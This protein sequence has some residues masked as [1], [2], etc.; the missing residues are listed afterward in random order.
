LDVS[1]RL[2]DKGMGMPVKLSAELVAAATRAAA[3]E[4]RSIARQIEY[5]A[6]LGRAT[7]TVLRHDEVLALKAVVAKRLRP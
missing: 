3:K 2:K 7:E 4:H 5:W 6:K 1:Q